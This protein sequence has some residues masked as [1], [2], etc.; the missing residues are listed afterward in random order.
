MKKRPVLYIIYILLALSLVGCTRAKAQQSEPEGGV[1]QPVSEVSVLNEKPEAPKP[2]EEDRADSDAPDV[3]DDGFQTRIVAG[4]TIKWDGFRAIEPKDDWD[5]WSMVLSDVGP[6]FEE[7]FEVEKSSYKLMEGQITET[8]V[9]QIHSPNP[10]P[11]V[12]IVGAVHGDERAAWYAAL[13]LK[14]A[15]ISCGDLYILVPANANGAR[16]LTR[17]VVKNQDLNRSFPGE[18]SGDEAEQLAYAIFCDIA[19][20][21]PDLVLDLHEAIVLSQDRDFLGS[22]YIFTELD[23]IEDLFFELLFATEEGRLCHNEFGFNG[24]GPAGSVNAE[25]TRNLRIPVI[26]VETFRGFDI[27]RRVYDQ[28]D[29]IQFVLDFMGMR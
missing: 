24:P 10:G 9:L 7:E 5:I 26:T 25:V 23:G 11:R 21:R 19:G 3:E 13:L 6:F 28:L 15:S 2:Q 22:T 8:E 27:G 1:A 4:E 16:N 14:Q 29:T 17:Y 20:K 18:P 12:Y